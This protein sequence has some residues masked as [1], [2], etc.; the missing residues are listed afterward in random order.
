MLVGKRWR[1]GR[2]SFKVEEGKQQTWWTCICGSH[3]REK[4]ERERR[5]QEERTRLL[6]ML[7]GKDE[8]ELWDFLPLDP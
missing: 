8:S 3:Y 2:R 1:W 5:G 4:T 7:P 6:C